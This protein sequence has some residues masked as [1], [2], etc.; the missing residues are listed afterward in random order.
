MILCGFPLLLGLLETRAHEHSQLTTWCHE[1]CKLNR[2]SAGS[3][4]M[5]LPDS[6][7]EVM[8]SYGAGLCAKTK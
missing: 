2:P 1:P 7:P 8:L 4:K 5:P 6:L 3:L